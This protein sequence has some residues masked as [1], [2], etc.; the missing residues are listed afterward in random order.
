MAEL[1]TR[2]MEQEVLLVDTMNAFNSINLLALLHNIDILCPAIS[3]YIYN[4]YVVPARLFIIGGNE[5]RFTEGTTQG[6]PTAMT[7]YALGCTSMMDRLYK[8]LLNQFDKK[9]Q[10]L[11]MT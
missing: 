10:R 6:D 9:C 2:Y 8:I 3:I 5:I 11:P 4:C 7:T 1:E